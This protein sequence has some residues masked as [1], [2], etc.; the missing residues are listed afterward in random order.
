[1]F[2]KEL[3]AKEEFKI[4]TRK[5][6]RFVEEVPLRELIEKN[7]KKLK[8]GDLTDKQIYDLL[9][10]KLLAV[11]KLFYKVM[12]KNPQIFKISQL[13]YRRKKLMKDKQLGMTFD[14]PDER[15]KFVVKKD[16]FNVLK[17]TKLVNF[18]SKFF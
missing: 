16:K 1:M 5:K 10:E 18:S 14:K 4:I 17:K 15:I 2:Q 12:E 7:N 6:A 11:Q 13:L 8:E 3:R 9:K